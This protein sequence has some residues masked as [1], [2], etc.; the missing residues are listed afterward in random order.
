[1]FLV[2]A[3]AGSGKTTYI[4]NRIIELISKY[5]NRKILCI[6]Y[7]NRAK[8]EL[9]HRINSK[10]VTINTIHA[11]ILEFISIY[12]YKAEVIDL[13]F[14]LFEDKILDGIN[15]GETDAKNQRYIEK[16]GKIDIEIIK[17]NIKG[18]SYNE[19]AFSSYYYGRISHD[20]LLYLFREMV[21]RFPVLKRRLSNKY[22]YI[23]IDEY[24]D[25]SANVLTAFYETTKNTTSELYLLGDKMQ[26]IYQNYDGSFNEKLEKFNTNLNLKKN[27][28]CSEKIVGVLNNL[29][30]NHE[31]N[32]I[33]SSSFKGEKPK[34]IIT[35][36]PDRESEKY[37]DKYMRLY[38][39]NRERFDQLGVSML[40][41]AISHMKAYSF[42]SKYGVV[43]VL[44]DKTNDNPDKLFKLLFLICDF[45]NLIEKKQYGA[46]IQLARRKHNL[47]CPD[48]TEIKYHINKIEFAKKAKDIIAKFQSDELTI[49]QFF[50]YLIKCD[51]CLDSEFTLICENDEYKEV[52]DCPLNELRKLY[53]Y[54]DSP[55][56]STQHGVKGEGHNNVCFIAENSSRNPITDM[57]GFFYLLCN[58][59]I[60]LTDFQNFYYDYIKIRKSFN[61]LGITSA[62]AYNSQSENCENFAKDVFNKF[63]GNIYFDFCIKE[64]FDKYFSSPNYTNFKECFTSSKVQGI[65]WAYKLFYVGC[66]RARLDLIIIVD[67]NNISPFEQQFIEKM[68]SIGFEVQ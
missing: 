61:K 48:L 4:E 66:S 26:E 17:E 1:M 49:K 22:S 52:L 19:Q 11:F 38:L 39:F 27:Y 23:F 57:Y 47:F 36:A 10:N 29:Y 58:E 41:K 46:A 8:E 55:K 2:N 15:K 18:I 67:K 14:D 63:N 12:F 7:T 51:Y 34:I 31:Y 24:Q 60:N 44:T 13:Y 9:Q 32:Q 16:Y 25:T 50:D 53:L 21:N 42:P 30:N 35:E 33:P 56:V 5:P 43:D 68:S 20:D 6:T 45:I 62:V 40:Y 64:K 59:N 3:P 28:R 37:S 65:L 54:L